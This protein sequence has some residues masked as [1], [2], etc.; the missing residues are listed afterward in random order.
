M[1]SVLPEGCQPSGASE[2]VM[3]VGVVAERLTLWVL[4]CLPELLAL[5]TI[6]RSDSGTVLGLDGV[7]QE[8]WH[9]G[10]TVKGVA[11]VPVTSC[12]KATGAHPVFGGR[13]V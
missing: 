9:Q 5:W 10:K 6:K 11:C 13:P 4:F 2:K 8:F 3:G 12:W 7:T 1:P